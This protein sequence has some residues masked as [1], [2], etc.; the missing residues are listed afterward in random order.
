MTKRTS[1]PRPTKASEFTIVFGTRQAAKGWQDVCAT[2]RN[3]VADAWDFL[4]RTPTERLPRNHPLKGELSTVTHAGREHAQWQHE[5]PGGAR[6]WF[7]V[8]GSK[9]V[10]VEVHT[11]HP[12]ATK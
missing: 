1:V 3:S 4:T 12:N 6:I 2:Q 5:L 11:H 10:L 7:Y 8:D 9:V